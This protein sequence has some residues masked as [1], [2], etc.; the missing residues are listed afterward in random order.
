MAI[1]RQEFV[2]EVKFWRCEW[3]KEC[4]MPARLNNEWTCGK[5]VCV[6]CYPHSVDHTRA[7]REQRAA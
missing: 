3:N 2:Q 4:Q 5:W 6:D 1:K 7:L